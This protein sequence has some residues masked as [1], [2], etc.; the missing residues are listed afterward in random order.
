MPP[1]FRA[2]SKAQVRRRKWKP[3]SNFI[4]GRHAGRSCWA[5]G[6]GHFHPSRPKFLRPQPF[7]LILSQRDS[8]EPAVTAQGFDQFRLLIQGMK[9]GAQ[10]ILDGLQRLQRAL[11]EVVFADVPPQAFG[12]IRVRGCAQ[13]RTPTSCPG[14]S[15][16]PRRRATPLGPETR[17]NGPARR[18]WRCEAK[19]RPSSRHP[20]IQILGQRDSLLRAGKLSDGPRIR[21]SRTSPKLIT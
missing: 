11:A 13:V 9:G 12:R 14:A 4:E 10:T 21:I 2:R 7:I 16:A 19:T 3:A 17:C 5:R 6:A 18:L 15:A 8:F 20:S 1:P